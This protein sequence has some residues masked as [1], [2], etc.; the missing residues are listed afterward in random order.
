MSLKKDKEKV[1]SEVF[2]DARIKSFLNYEPP[3]GV[4]ADLHLLEKA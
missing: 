3:S 1:L 2:D 4:S